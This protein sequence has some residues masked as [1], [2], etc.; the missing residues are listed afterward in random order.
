MDTI[1][2][3]DYIA[4]GYLQSIIMQA[5]TTF[6]ATLWAMYET[7]QLSQGVVTPPTYEKIC[8]FLTSL[9]KTI[10]SVHAKTGV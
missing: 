6:Y 2:A 4:L 10:V 3:Q 7:S 9:D 8:Q 5:L 1:V